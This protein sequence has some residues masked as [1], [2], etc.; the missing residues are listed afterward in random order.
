MEPLAGYFD[1]AATSPLRPAARAAM[2]DVGPIANPASTHRAGQR[3]SA[4]LEESRERVAAMVGAH[5][6]EVIFVSGGTEAVNL[7]LKG[8][9]LREPAPVISAAIEHHATLDTL[10]WV[11]SMGGGVTYIGCDDE[12]VT[13]AA[14][15]AE[16]ITPGAIATISAVNNE[17]GVLQPISPI[18]EAAAASGALL[19]LDAVAAVGHVPF[20]FAASG[21]QFASIAAHKLGGPVGIGALLTARS[22]S[23]TPLVH[24]GG[25][26]RGIRSGTG[27][28]TAAVGFAAAIE[29]A[30]GDLE[31]E[32][33]R[34]G[35]F[36]GRLRD[37]LTGL[38]GVR[39]TGTGMA[40]P[41][42]V[43]FT[44]EGASAEALTFLLDERGFATSNG[45]ACT[46]GVVQESHVMRAM[47]RGG[48]PLR[49][50]LG[51]S[52]TAD[53]V[54]ALIAAL[55]ETIARARRSR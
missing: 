13:D 14:Q 18:S 4:L 44:V 53:E 23:V 15:F 54:D 51:W 9:W 47:A 25:Q 49:I 30:V 2:L 34:L 17:T 24:G 20:S 52:T 16:R 45:S 8:A 55:P 40:V 19:H 41:N 6:T 46:A 28:V 36:T 39:V 26:Q 22:A 29:A 1:H 32:S 35:V 10:E 7:A 31:A 38:E 3:A 5:P 33:E 43:H 11:E 21:A 12:S 37:C 42:L 48:A 27:D 50:S